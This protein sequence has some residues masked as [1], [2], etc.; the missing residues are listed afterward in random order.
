MDT[1]EMYYTMFLFAICIVIVIAYMTQ[2]KT[3]NNA[4]FY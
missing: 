4:S 1:S 2:K 3:N